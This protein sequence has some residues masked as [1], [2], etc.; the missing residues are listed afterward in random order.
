MY[1]I[2]QNQFL[3]CN[4]YLINLKLYKS[5]KMQNKIYNVG[6]KNANISLDLLTFPSDWKVIKI[7]Q[8]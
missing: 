2:N 8:Y 4:T 6:L 7:L 1:N 3:T 5:L